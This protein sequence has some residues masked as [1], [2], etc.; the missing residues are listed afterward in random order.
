MNQDQRTETGKVGL[1]VLSPSEIGQPDRQSIL[2]IVDVKLASAPEREALESLALRRRTKR[3]TDLNVSSFNYSSETQTLRFAIWTKMPQLAADFYLP[4]FHIS[5][6]DLPIIAT[7][8][9]DFCWLMSEGTTPENI[10]QSRTSPAK[11]IDGRK[12]E[13]GDLAWVLPSRFADDLIEAMHI[14]NEAFFEGI[15]EDAIIYGPL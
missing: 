8:F 15:L 9:P 10:V 6:S 5:P 11:E 7:T 13:L 14:L 12:V 4:S 3:G 1:T 2:A